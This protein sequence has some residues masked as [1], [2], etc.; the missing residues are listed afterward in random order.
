MSVIGADEKSGFAQVTRREGESVES[1]AARMYRASGG[2]TPFANLP[3][4][5]Q[6]RWI[7]KAKPKMGPLPRK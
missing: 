1:L 5:D 2:Q 3:I 7:D 4:A 6:M